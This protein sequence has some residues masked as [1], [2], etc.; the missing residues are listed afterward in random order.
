MNN[1]NSNVST[2]KSVKPPR[3]FRLFLIVSL[4]LMVAIMLMAHLGLQSVFRNNIIAEAEKDA[5]RISTA[6][7]N[8]KIQRL[9]ED[10]FDG[11]ER[12]RVSLVGGNRFSRSRAHG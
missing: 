1:D 3:H 2:S 4:G 11:T 7:S 9:V 8:F 12:A 10:S 5:L 6:L